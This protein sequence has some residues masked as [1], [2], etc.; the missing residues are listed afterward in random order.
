MSDAEYQQML[1]TGRVVESAGGGITSVIFPSDK[2]AYRAAPPTDS[3]VE[4]D[5]EDAR[6]F[7]LPP[8]GKIFGPSCIFARKYG[9]TDM[10]V[11]LNPR[12]IP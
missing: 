2:L 10:P 4:F 3:Y 12:R 5:T 6:V 11:A 1:T 9:I 8:W 7:K